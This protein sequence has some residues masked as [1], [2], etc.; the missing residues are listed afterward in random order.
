MLHS[1]KYNIKKILNNVLLFFFFMFAVSDLV[2]LHLRIFF[3]SEVNV[4]INF[5]G[6]TNTS[7]VK[8]KDGKN[9]TKPSNHGGNTGFTTPEP[10]I[11][12]QNLLTCSTI[13][14]PDI[15]SFRNTAFYSVL[16]P[17]APPAA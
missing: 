14:F 17:R 8:V 1:G 2:E 9:K 11:S 3:N 12:Q 7:H 4:N 13:S 10:P 5:S 6:K 15:F 16:I